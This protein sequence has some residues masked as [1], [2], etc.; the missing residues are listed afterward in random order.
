MRRVSSRQRLVSWDAFDATANHA[1]ATSSSEEE[2]YCEHSSP[3]SVTSTTSRKRDRSKQKKSP[4]SSVATRSVLNHHSHSHASRTP[5]NIPAFPW[6]FA[7]FQPQPIDQLPEDVYLYTCS[8]LDLASIRNLMALNH[9]FRHLLL[10]ADSLWMTKC[11]TLWEG[12]MPSSSSLLVDSTKIP[13]A[14]AGPNCKMTANL[15]LLI[16]MTP[17][18]LP[19]KVDETLLGTCRRIHRT[20]RLQQNHTLRILERQLTPQETDEL[21]VTTCQNKRS[22]QYTGR[23]GSGDRCIRSNHPLPR[24]TRR[25]NKNNKF[26][27]DGKHHSSIFDLLCRSSTSISKNG[28]ASFLNV[29]KPFVAPYVSSDKLLQVGPRM[30]AYFEVSIMEFTGGEKKSPFRRDCVAVGVATESFSCQTRMPGWDA[31][32]F[33]YHGDDG[34]TFHASGAMLERFG[35]CFGTGD[36]VGCGIDYVAR[37]IF[38]TLNGKFLGYGWKQIDSEFLENNLYGVVGIDTNDPVSV[39]YGD[40]PFQFNLQ[41]FTSKHDTLITHEYQHHHHHHSK[42]VEEEDSELADLPSYPEI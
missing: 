41:Q 40:A 18:K 10:S 25:D 33:G 11:Q 8:F 12:L 32:S 42:K 17:D 20:V 22:I 35:P 36:T 14:V 5:L 6:E 26:C 13:T 23:V 15:P 7:S 37:G 39:N 28:A 1:E 4:L 29:W 34:G 31:Q 3:Q 38:Y 19:T 24:P 30:V 21:V 9:K 16:S 2:E 27:K